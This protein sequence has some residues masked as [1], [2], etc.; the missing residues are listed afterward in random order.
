MRAPL[1]RQCPCEHPLVGWSMSIKQTP[2]VQASSFAWP[3]SNHLGSMAA[4]CARRRATYLLPN[5]ARK[6]RSSP[7]YRLGCENLAMCCP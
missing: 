5:P 3:L 6:T 1:H 7:Q 2:H 4:A